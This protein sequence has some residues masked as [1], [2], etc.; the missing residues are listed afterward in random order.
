MDQRLTIVGLG[1][2]DLEKATD[3]YTNILGWTKEI[4]YNPF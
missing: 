4:A 3:F 2:D 1:V